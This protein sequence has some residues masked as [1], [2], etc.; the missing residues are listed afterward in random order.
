MGHP[1]A[2]PNFK[3]IVHK[4]HTLVKIVRI[5]LLL[6][7]LLG[8]LLLQLVVNELIHHFPRNCAGPV[9]L[10]ATAICDF[11]V[12]SYFY[13]PSAQ[14]AVA[15]ASFTMILRLTDNEYMAN[16]YGE[17]NCRRN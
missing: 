2:L 8:L 10:S 13:L 12:S 6:H 4:V 11:D 7:T 5:D 14:A 16:H 17:Q 1:E 9:C 15:S 3:N